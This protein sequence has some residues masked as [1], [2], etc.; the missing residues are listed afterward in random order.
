MWGDEK[1]LSSTTVNPSVQE[2]GESTLRPR[3]LCWEDRVI[4]ILLSG[5]AGKAKLV[6]S[7]AWLAAVGAPCGLVR[8]PS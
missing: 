6:W 1:Q 7:S 2:L 5:T 8:T 4:S 3:E